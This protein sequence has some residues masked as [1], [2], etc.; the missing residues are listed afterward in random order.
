LK[1][2]GGKMKKL[3][4]LISLTAL[5][6]LSACK[7]TPTDADLQKAAT[8]KVANPAVTVAVK[9]GVAT[10]SGELAT[11]ADID[12]AVAAAKVEGVKS[13][14]SNLKVKPTPAPIATPDAALKATVE[15]A[16]KKKG[17]NEVTVDATDKIKLGGTVAKGKKQD[18]QAT[19]A[20]AGKKPVDISGLTEK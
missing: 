14:T 15:G 6:A 17:F 12:K 16:L 20:E 19:A 3:L 5:L 4:L 11:Q 8:E 2:S 7:G 13:V 18:A 1:F 9:D 10:V